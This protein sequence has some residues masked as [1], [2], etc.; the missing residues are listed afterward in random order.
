[1]LRKHRVRLPIYRIPK[2]IFPDSLRCQ[3]F[4]KQSVQLFLRPS[5][6]RHRTLFDCCQ[7]RFDRFLKRPVTAPAYHRLKA[8]LLLRCKINCHA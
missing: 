1:M 7:C 6:T 5:K 3:P 2:L 8:P 4:C